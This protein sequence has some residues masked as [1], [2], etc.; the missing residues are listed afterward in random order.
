[1][2]SEVE[3]LWKARQRDPGGQDWLLVLDLS[4]RVDGETVNG[5]MEEGADVWG[6][7]SMSLGGN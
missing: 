6:G 3:Q 7:G 1:M 2:S 4:A 5:A